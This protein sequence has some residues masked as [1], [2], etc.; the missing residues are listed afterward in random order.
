MILKSVDPVEVFRSFTGEGLPSPYPSHRPFLG[1]HPTTFSS[2][3]LVCAR[4][5]V[6][7]LHGT[8]KNTCIFATL[9]FLGRKYA[10]ILHGTLKNT[11][12]FDTCAHWCAKT[13]RICMHSVWDHQKH[14][15]FHYLCSLGAKFDVET[16][17]FCLWMETT[18]FTTLLKA[19]VARVDTLGN[20]FAYMPKNRVFLHTLKATSSPSA[21]NQ[22]VLDTFE[23]SGTLSGRI[24]NPLLAHMPTNNMF[25][26]FEG[27]A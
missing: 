3:G 26:H 1:P 5:Y 21:R 19:L 7:I 9:A 8:L 20:L 15:S 13:R 6:Y 23:A 18:C 4:K 16:R 25:C 14:S 11:C 2:L 10:Y 12:V 27:H 17:Y 22:Y 24:W